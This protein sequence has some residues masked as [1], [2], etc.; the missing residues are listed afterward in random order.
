MAN[1]NAIT[2]LTVMM[3]RLSVVRKSPEEMT[4]IAAITRKPNAT[5][6]Q[7]MF[8]SPSSLRIRFEFV[9]VFR[10][11]G[12]LPALAYFLIPASFAGPQRKRSCWIRTRLIDGAIGRNNLPTAP[13][14]NTSPCSAF[15]DIER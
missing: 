12:R 6:M 1:I 8:K 3:K 9:L 4:L 11:S 2:R 15:L 7:I 10:L 14:T 13:R 5:K